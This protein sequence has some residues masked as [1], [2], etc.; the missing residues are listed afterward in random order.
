LQQLDAPHKV[1]EQQQVLA[2][3]VNPIA[4]TRS[5]KR[6]ILPV[7]G[8]IY[9]NE[10]IADG[11]YLTWGEMLRGFSRM[12]V[13]STEFGSEEQL[14]KNMLALRRCTGSFGRNSAVPLSSNLLIARTRSRLG[15]HYRSINTVA[16]WTCAH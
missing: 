11:A 10:W 1:S 12:P 3:K 2:T 13:G 4:G 15:R 6:A 8:E 16:V 5:G 7:V 9:E 14:V